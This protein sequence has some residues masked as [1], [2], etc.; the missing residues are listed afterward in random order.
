MVVPGDGPRNN[1]PYTLEKQAADWRQRS[2]SELD[3]KRRF[4]MR[5]LA[6]DLEEQARRALTPRA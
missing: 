1:D 3:P 2:N 5:S 6:A 4:Q